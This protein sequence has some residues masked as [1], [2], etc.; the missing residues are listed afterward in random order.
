MATATKAYRQAE[1]KHSAGGRSPIEVHT[2]LWKGRNS[3]G[4]TV[5]GELSGQSSAEIKVLLR[6]QGVTPLNVRKKPKALFERKKKVKPA[7]I[8]VVTRQIAT[9]LIAGVPL[10]TVLEMVGRGHENEAVRNL[11]G[12]ILAEVQSGTPLSKALRPHRVHF[13][14]LYCDLVAAG[15]MSGTLD[16]VFDRI[17]TYREK[18][19]ALKSKIK[20]AMFYPVAVIVV[21]VLVTAILLL[22]V[23]PQFESIFN[24]FGAELPLFT[25]MVINLSRFLQES[26][27]YF[28]A[29]ITIMIWMFVRSHRNSQ[30]F[31]DKVDHFVLKIP[32]VGPI[33]HK[34]AIARF[35]RTLATTFAAGVPL[36]EG[37]E[38]SAGASGNALY[39]DAITKVREEVISGLQMNIAMRTTGVFPDMLTQMVMIGEESG[40]LDDMLNK[41]ANIYEMEVDDAVDGLSTLIEPMLMVVIGGIVGGLVVAMYLPIFQLGNVVG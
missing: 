29:I 31:R 10:V 38:S 24:D 12:T 18:A 37:L 1:A 4:K 20:K 36:V 23:V 34:A 15:E 16:T 19:E 2:F 27:Y 8:A 35:A 40:S 11:L 22:F 30:T 39:R 32:A 5:Q 21:A 33:L 3:K 6:K 9:M 14:D 28:F 13:D 26:W 17:A 41:V 25:Q 7:D